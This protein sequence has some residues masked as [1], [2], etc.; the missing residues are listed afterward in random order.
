[1]ENFMVDKNNN[2]D[3]SSLSG[4]SEEPITAKSKLALTEEEADEVN[5]KLH[6]KYNSYLSQAG[7]R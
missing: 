4:E 3:P 6:A 7:S 1:M 5:Q 2:N